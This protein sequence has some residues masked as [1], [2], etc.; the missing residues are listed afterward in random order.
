MLVGHK[1]LKLVSLSYVQ[2]AIHE[3]LV[4]PNCEG[5]C[6]PWM[7]AEKDDW[8]PRKAS[9]FLWLN[10]E[11]GTDSATAYDVVSKQAC[12]EKPKIEANGGISNDHTQSNHQILKNTECV[13][14]SNESLDII[15]L[16]SSSTNALDRTLQEL[17]T[18]LLENDEAHGDE[19]HK[20][21]EIPDSQPP[22]NSL[23]LSDKHNYSIEEDDARPKR[24]GRKARMLDLG[25]KMGEKLEEKRRH[26]EE[27]SKQIVEKMRGS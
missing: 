16:P 3:T 6:I 23:I 1:N 15:P 10:Q 17:R 4:L 7:L 20:G 2:G 25:K 11:S 22:S 13:Q 5:V 14:P 19:K 24:M 21:E 8:V 9:P 18:P 12:N 27:K 26:I